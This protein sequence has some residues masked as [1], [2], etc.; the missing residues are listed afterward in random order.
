MIRSHRLAESPRGIDLTPLLDVVFIMLIFFIVTATFVREA[1][2]DLPSRSDE[3]LDPIPTS[4][5]ILVDV[6]FE[7]RIHIA[8]RY[9]DKRAVA[10]YLQRLHAENPERAVVIRLHGEANA[11]TLVY[12][13]DRARK[14]G[15]TDLKLADA[16]P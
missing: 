13:M 15:I 16:G 12:V 14:I 6:T 3:P 11:D 2:I 5:A 1:G 10:A 8:G 7:N 9:V 4:E